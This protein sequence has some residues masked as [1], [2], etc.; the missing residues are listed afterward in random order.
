MRPH[1]RR[2]HPSH[3]E[4]RSD[5]PGSAGGE[6]RHIWGKSG[7]RPEGDTTRRVHDRTGRIPLL[8]FDVGFVAQRAAAA[9][10]A[11]Q[12]MVTG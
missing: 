8:H 2:R 9:P 4:A 12:I 11:T 6:P 1:A 3:R 10:A 5:S 7:C